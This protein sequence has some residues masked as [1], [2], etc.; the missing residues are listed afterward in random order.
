[1]FYT[2]ETPVNTNLTFKTY[3]QNNVGD[4]STTASV[5]KRLTVVH[6]SLKNRFLEDAGLIFK[7]WTAGRD[8]HKQMNYVNLKKTVE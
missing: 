8:S 6:I 1:M 2:D 5:S 7:V 3:W 4:I